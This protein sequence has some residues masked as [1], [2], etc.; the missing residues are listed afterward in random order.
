MEHIN[1][2]TEEK[3]EMFDEIAAHFYN[4]NFGQMSK[5]NMELLMFSF[6][7]NKLIQNNKF[8]D[9]TIDYQK[10]SDYRISKELGITQQRVQ[11]LKIKKTACLSNRV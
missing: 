1:F 10:C 6:Y 11:N 2:T 9:G 7:M 8:E 3:A 5:S 4:A